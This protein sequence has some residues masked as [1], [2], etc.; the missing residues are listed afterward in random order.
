[1]EPPLFVGPAVS[2]RTQLEFYC[3]VVTSETD[4]NARFRVSFTFDSEVD[5]EVPAIDVDVTEPRATLHERYLAGRLH[6][7]VKWTSCVI[8]SKLSCIIYELLFGKGHLS[9]R[10]GEQ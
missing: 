5:P 10:Y 4:Q 3:D 7:T 2:G 8:I 6:K 1:M 9:E